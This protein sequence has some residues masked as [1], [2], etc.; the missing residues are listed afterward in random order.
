MEMSMDLATGRVVE[1]QISAKRR[2][3]ARLRHD[4][5]LQEAQMQA[6]ISRDLDCAAAAAQL[7]TMRRRLAELISERDVLMETLIYTPKAG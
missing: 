2:E 1:R 7:L 5:R 3:I 4:M 6:L